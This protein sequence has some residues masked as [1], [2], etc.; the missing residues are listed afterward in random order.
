MGIEKHENVGKTSEPKDD[1]VCTKE[2]LPG[3]KKRKSSVEKC[4]DAMFDK[5]KQTADADFER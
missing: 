2:K 1:A 4:L 5:M 3:K